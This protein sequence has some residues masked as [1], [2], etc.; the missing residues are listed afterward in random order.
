MR[1]LQGLLVVTLAASSCSKARPLQGDLAQPVSWEEDVAPLF[2]AQCNSCHSGATARAGY[3]TTSYLEAL[4]PQSAPVAVAGDA[5]S[6]LLRTIDPAQADAV[7]APVS[8]AYGTARAWVVDGRLSF[9]RSG[10]HQGGIMN[11][12]DPEFHSNLVRGDNW[13]FARCQGCHGADLSGG[14]AGASCQECH[15]LQVGADGTAT[16]SSCH[17]SAQSPAPPHDLS[18]NTNPSARGVGAHQ[19]HLF[20]RTVISAPIAC[21]VCHQVPADVS[22]PGH[23]DHPRPA[24]VTFSGLALAGGATPTWNG[25]S[26][27]N[28]CCH[29]GGANLANDTAFQLRT[30]VWTLGTSQA[31]C[32]SC[33]GAP[34]GNSTHAGITFP[35]CARCHSSTVS[36]TGI[37]LVSGPPEARTSTHINGVID[38][39]P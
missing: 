10:T 5:S 20:G 31:F 13:N 12:H 6:L 22:S 33:H 36:P 37:I 38:V 35:D 16:C 24:T 3:R 11:P 19:A 29:G 1:A 25:A 23:L 7:H 9:F 26:C 30:P 15:S 4:G 27:S 14:K 28:S 8:A 21:T 17:G 18:G 34:P 32:G 2:A 39:T